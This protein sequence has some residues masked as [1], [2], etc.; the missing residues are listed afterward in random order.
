MILNDVKP[1]MKRQQ[2]SIMTHT[3]HVAGNIPRNLTTLR[4]KANMNLNPT[5][6]LIL[7]P[8]LN[9]LTNKTPQRNVMHTQRNKPHPVGD[10]VTVCSRVRL[11]NQAFI[12]KFSYDSPNSCTLTPRRL[13][14][15]M[16]FTGNLH[17]PQLNLRSINNVEYSV[18]NT[19]TLRRR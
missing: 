9:I 4:A 5:H 12:K 15:S 3:A 7:L 8:T 16:D 18:L 1:T 10:F 17:W 13:V 19:P 6:K 11:Q 14:G 2:T